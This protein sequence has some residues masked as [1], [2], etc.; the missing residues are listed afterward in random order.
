[1]A[2]MVKA[3]QAITARNIYDILGRL[4][5]VNSSVLLVKDS[6]AANA[7]SL[8]GLMSLSVCAGEVFEL[9]TKASDESRVLELLGEYFVREK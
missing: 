7:K 4:K 2:I 3:T 1:M 8:L 6:H 5:D 9:V